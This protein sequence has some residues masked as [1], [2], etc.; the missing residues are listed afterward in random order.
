M[1]ARRR[2]A[3]D[4]FV[5][6]LAPEEP[7]DLLFTEGKPVTEFDDGKIS[8]L[9]CDKIDDVPAI[10]HD[11]CELIINAAQ[12]YIEKKLKNDLKT[13]EGIDERQGHSLMKATNKLF[14]ARAGST[15][16]PF[17]T[18]NILAWSRE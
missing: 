18:V 11:F 14:K 4:F 10:M 12:R 13:E 5:G 2:S 15:S 17:F 1:A 8:F 7:P 16:L 3:L 6:E 9:G